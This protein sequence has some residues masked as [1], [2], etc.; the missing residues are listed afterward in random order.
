MKLSSPKVAMTSLLLGVAMSVSVSSA[1]IVFGGYA[2]APSSSYALQTENQQNISDQERGILLFTFGD[3]GALST[4]TLNTYAAPWKVA[5]ASL[6]LYTRDVSASVDASNTKNTKITTE[7]VNR[8]LQ[9]YGFITPKHVQNWHQVLGEDAKDPA[10][11]K[12]EPIWR[13]PL[14]MVSGMLDAPPVHV[15]ITN[16]GCATCHTGKVYDERGNPTEDAWL[17]APNTSL[18]LDAYAKDLLKSFRALLQEKDDK[19]LIETIKTLYPETTDGEIQTIRLVVLPKI[20]TR[21]ENL[22]APTHTA[23]HAP[24]DTTTQVRDSFVPYSISEPGLTNGVASIKLQLGLL[25]KDVDAHDE[26][27]AFASIPDL[28]FRHLRSSF[29]YDG[30]YAPAGQPRFHPIEESEVDDTLLQET[31]RIPAVFTVGTLGLTP[32]RGVE[33]LDDTVFV[34]R[35]LQKY[36]PQAFPAVVDVERAQQGEE[37][38]QASCLRCHGTYQNM[39]EAKINVQTQKYDEPLRLLRYPNVL[40]PTHVVGT[41]SARADAVTEPVLGR[42]QDT[43]FA[44]Y[45][46]TAATHGYVAPILSGLW[47][48]AP[49][50]HNGSVPTLASLVGLDTRPARFWVGGHR[51]DYQKVGIALVKRTDSSPV[52]DPSQETWVYP[53]EY[54]PWSTPQTY[55]VS[56]AGHANTGH[57]QFFQNLTDAEKW[58]LLEYLKLL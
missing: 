27:Y 41:D 5:T 20:K 43:D 48:S 57:E 52:L 23:T 14:G 12:A 33:N 24:T 50:L 32:K 26:E 21:I 28:A 54:Q 4:E 29:L 31:G 58:A 6:W 56:K 8:L 22:D 36:R 47:M 7:D 40:L 34:M 51:L 13:R 42:F 9:R 55:D 37:I 49:Y 10:Q 44:K 46:D 3:W 18:N 25:E 15:E 35:A 2:K 39:K 38:Y 1:C 19:K 11:R 53:K 17:F 45:V 30:I 16:N